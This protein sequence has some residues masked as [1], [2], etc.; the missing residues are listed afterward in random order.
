MKLIRIIGKTAFVFLAITYAVCIINGIT[1][2]EYVATDG[3]GT[4]VIAG[5]EVE[6]HGAVADAFWKTYTQAESRAAE[7]LPSK[8]R[9]AVSRIS[10]L[11]E[12]GK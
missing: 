5:K 3:S 7:W 4:L 1:V 2:I 8:I 6:V 12:R 11:L 9:S 10:D